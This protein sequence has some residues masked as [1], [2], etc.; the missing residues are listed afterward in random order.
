MV[1]TGRQNFLKKM[2]PLDGQARQVKSSSQ[3]VNL[4]GAWP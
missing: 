4:P 1:F 2:F 3:L